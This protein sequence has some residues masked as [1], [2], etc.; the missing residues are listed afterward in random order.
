MSISRIVLCIC[1]LSLMTV[2]CAQ[3]KSVDSLIQDLESGYDKVRHQATIDLLQRDKEE[4]VPPLIE[5]LRTGTKQA[6]YMAVQ[7]LGKMNDRR[8]VEP[9]IVLLG[10]TN[11]QHIRAATAEAL[12]NLKDPRAT[13]A[14]LRCMKDPYEVVRLKTTFALGGLSDLRIVAPLIAALGD[15]TTGIRASALV[16]LDRI[17]PKVTDDVQ[18]R[19]ILSGIEQTAEDTSAAVRYVAVQLLGSMGDRKAVP[20]LIES[21]KDENSPIRKKAAQSLGELG[22][23]RAIAPLK[24]LVQNGSEEERDTAERA[25]KRIMEGENVPQ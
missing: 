12:G 18:K 3:K 23:Q 7:I 21:L 9:L 1:L 2:G 14:L 4:V 15:S 6:K 20:I 5:V 16:S 24:D 13:D 22:D 17:W 10:D 19:Q 8:A 25:L 11:H